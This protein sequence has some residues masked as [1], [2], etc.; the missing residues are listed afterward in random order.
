MPPLP[1]F[2]VLKTDR[3]VCLEIHCMTSFCSSIEYGNYFDGQSVVRTKGRMLA[4]TLLAVAVVAPVHA[5]LGAH[6]LPNRAD[7]V[8]LA[9]DGQRRA[10]VVH[11]CV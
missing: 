9:G 4:P 1:S 11:A 3:A 10:S 2:P 8:R 6:E 5:A 7:A